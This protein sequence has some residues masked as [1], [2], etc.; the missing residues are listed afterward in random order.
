MKKKFVLFVSVAATLAAAACS[1]GSPSATTPSDSA[2]AA[3]I[4]V[5]ASTDV[6]GNI[7]ET[8]G[9]NQIAVTSI[10][11]DPDKDP[12]TY[13]ADASTQLAL[14][15]AQIVIENGG[16]YDD[17]VDTM[18]KASGKQPTVINVSNLSG[19]DQHPANG[20]FNEHVWYDFPTVD[21]LADSLATELGAADPAHQ[22]EFAANADTFKKNVQQLIDD[23]ATIKSKH[24]GEAVAITEPV[25][26]YLLTAAGLKNATPDKFSEAIEEDT[27]VP[28]T[29]LKDTLALFSNKQVKALVYNEQTS[30]PQTEAV[31]AAAKKNNIPVVPVTE[32]LPS[33]QDYLS[34]MTANVKAVSA[35]LGS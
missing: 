4:A 12:H 18:L 26:L 24:A 22:Q 20:E 3:P 6:Y 11:D 23:E 19:H 9:G 5:V 8:I 17:F 28:P 21:K 1:S 35:A 34:W 10:I 13:E 30:G 16:G 2:S 25:P 15:K 14:S 33:G 29:V 31:L 27:D 32:T 7:A